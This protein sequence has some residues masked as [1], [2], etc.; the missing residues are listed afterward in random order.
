MAEQIQSGKALKEVYKITI[1]FPKPFARLP[2]VVISPLWENS[3]DA[4]GYIDTITS[5]SLES[6]T[7]VGKNMASN[8]YVS[9]IASGVLD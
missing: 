6:F 4:V 2:H 5:V 8:Y 3:E 9:W 1:P 7:V